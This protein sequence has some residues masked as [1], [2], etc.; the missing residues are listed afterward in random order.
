[1]NLCRPYKPKNSNMEAEGLKT[2]KAVSTSFSGWFLLLERYL[3][4]FEI[5][6]QNP[7]LLI[8]RICRATTAF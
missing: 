3:I 7:V 4:E 8:Y 6:D 5:S 1:M 2:P